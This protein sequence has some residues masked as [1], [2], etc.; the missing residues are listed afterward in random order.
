[1]VNKIKYVAY[2]CKCIQKNKS[3]YLDNYK[4]QQLCFYRNLV[5]YT[6]FKYSFKQ[7]INKWHV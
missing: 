6:I 5:Y 7:F 1:M 2:V 3:V 4:G